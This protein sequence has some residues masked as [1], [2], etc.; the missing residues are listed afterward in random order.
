MKKLIFMPLVV[1]ALLPA[2][3]L[4]DDTNNPLS[5][6]EIV[7]GLK[8]ALTV[9]TDSS[10]TITS[11]A[12]GYFNDQAIKILLPPEAKP[13]LDNMSYVS[14]VTKIL[15]LPLV[16]SVLGVNGQIPD[17]EGMTNKAILSMNRAAESAAKQAA[18]IFKN[19]ITSLSITEG[20][21]ILNGKNPADSSNTKS[22]AAFDSTAATAY[23]ISTTKT[24]LVNAY[25]TP[26]DAE[27]NKDLGLGISS[28]DAWETLV[29]NYNIVANIS[30][31]ILSENATYEAG[32]G[33]LGV[34][35]LSDSQ[36]GYLQKFAPIQETTLGTYVTNKALDGLFVKVGDQEKNIR[37]DPW[38]WASSLVGDIL[39]KV[40]GKK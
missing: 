18:P 22:G 6:E 24:Q 13:I 16:S 37:K 7:K 27:L 34:K 25:K 36:K 2:C 32:L 10:V 40:F 38:Q 26:I 5:S 15:S 4:L 31:L 23:L 11:A 33:M 12:N 14:E 20:L 9:G 21:N 30:A 17:I 19:S 29:S 3:E 1:L 8:T 28:N 35:I 39:T